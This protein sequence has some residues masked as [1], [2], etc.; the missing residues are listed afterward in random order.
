MEK[1]LA[2]SFGKLL[3]RTAHFGPSGNGTPYISDGDTAR[4]LFFVNLSGAYNG[5]A[6]IEEANND[7][8]II[9]ERVNAHDDLSADAARL[10]Y[11]IAN[12]ARAIDLL[13]R[14]QGGH[15]GA[16]GFIMFVDGDM[17]KRSNSRGQ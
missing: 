17:R 6:R 4:V 11:L 15:L 8:R 9:S 14:L 16:E 7:M 10:E 12:P 13:T 2:P 1:K 3:A 5:N